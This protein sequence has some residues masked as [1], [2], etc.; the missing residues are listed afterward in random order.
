ML[1][2]RIKSALGIPYI[3]SLHGVWDVDD[4]RTAMARLKARFRVKLNGVPWQMPMRVIAGLCADRGDAREFG[5]NTSL[6]KNT[7]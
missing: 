6:K 1:A 5:G 3:M 2:S 4:R 7:Q